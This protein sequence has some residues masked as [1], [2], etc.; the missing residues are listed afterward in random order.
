MKLMTPVKAVNF[1]INMHPSLYASAGIEIAKLR[2]YDHIFNVIGN[3][4]RDSDEFVDCLRDRRKGVQTPPAKYLSGERLHYAYTETEDFGEGDCKFSMPKHG[5]SLDEVFTEAEKADHPEVK[6]WLGFN[7]SS[8]FIPYPN[9]Q[10][11]YSTVWQ[12]DTA[13]LTMDW[14][15]EIIWF[16]RKCEDF[17]DGPDAH[18][19]HRAVTTDPKKLERRIK[20]QEQF[21]EKYRKETAS[22]SEFWAAIT[23][24]WQCEYRGDTLDFL[25]RRWQKEHDKIRA[26][27]TET[28]AMLEGLKK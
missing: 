13:L 7:V 17:F 3:G 19:Y 10:K 27:I 25:Q 1:N 18:E 12:I 5:S 9:F 15:E 21:F 23:E 22:E 2:V 4:I 20:D 16:Y 26:F 24:N 6:Y 8:K 14:I 28:I 11:E